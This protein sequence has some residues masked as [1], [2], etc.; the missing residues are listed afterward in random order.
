MYGMCIMVDDRILFKKLK[1]E[2]LVL[3][4]DKNLNLN[5]IY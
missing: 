5:R 2:F 4:G 3:R 1:K